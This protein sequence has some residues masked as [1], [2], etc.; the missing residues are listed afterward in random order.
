MGKGYH[1][2]NTGRDMIIKSAGGAKTTYVHDRENHM[3]SRQ[4]SNG[5]SIYGHDDDGLRLRIRNASGT[6][7]IVW[8]GSDYLG[9]IS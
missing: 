6:L 3:Q 9:E 7:T 5:I 4:T 8:D 2:D 1:N